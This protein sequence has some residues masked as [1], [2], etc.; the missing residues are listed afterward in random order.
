MHRTSARDTFAIRTFSDLP[1]ALVAVPA[2]TAVLAALWS[3]QLL[4]ATWDRLSSWLRLGALSAR[5]PLASS[6]ALGAAVSL[7]GATDAVPLQAGARVP[8]FLLALLAWS[9]ATAALLTL[10][11]SL[12]AIRE[13]GERRWPERWFARHLAD[14]HDTILVR[15]AIHLSVVVIPPFL[16]LLIERQ[17]TP[18][19]LIFMAA[20]Y[21][22]AADHMEALDH[23][24]IHRRLLRGDKQRGPARWVLAAGAFYLEQVLP[25]MCL[26]MPGWYRI[27]HLYM[28]HAENSGLLD[29]QSTN[30]YPTGYIGFCLSALD[31]AVS[32]LLPVDLFLYLLRRRKLPAARQLAAAVVRHYAVLGAIAWVHPAFALSFLLLRASVGGVTSTIYFY[33]WHGLVLRGDA[34]S[35]FDNT[36]DVVD[37][38]VDHAFLGENFHVEHHLHPSRHWSQMAGDF[39]RHTEDRTRAATPVFVLRDAGQANELRHAIF[40]ALWTEDCTRLGPLLADPATLTA[41]AERP[42]SQ[43]RWYRRCDR[44]LGR[45]ALE[46]LR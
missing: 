36:I 16:L 2:S 3:Y 37:R 27:Q 15:T 39:E 12:A 22:V 7:L 38:S 34:S 21:L 9:R 17:L 4:G 32:L 45:F 8:L 1:K 42:A 6:V 20:G 23:I 28:H 30:R 5:A 14:P 29:N 31:F 25:M 24:N 19:A 11:S 10:P 26:R 35:V 46:F 43:R 40:A 18:Y 33:L 44:A 13:A 41:L